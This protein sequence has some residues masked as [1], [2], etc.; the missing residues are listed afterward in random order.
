M[1]LEALWEAIFSENPSRIRAAWQQLSLEERSAVQTLLV[2]IVRDVQRIEEQRQA[3]RV[4]LHALGYDVP[5]SELSEM[6]MFAR[7]VAEDVGL[8]LEEGFGQLDSSLKADGSLVTRW[9]LIADQRIRSAIAARYPS[10]AI[11]SEEHSHQWHGEE[12]CWVIDPIDGTTN[13]ACGVPIWG[14]S[15]GLLRQG[16]PVLGV[17]EFPMFQE[18]Y[19]A[20]R[21][22]G[23]W[24]NGKRVQAQPR[25][26]P[27]IQPNDLFACCTRTLQAGPVR[28]PA[29]L[30]VPGTTAYNL[31]LV[32]RGACIGSFDL[33]VH[34]WDVAALWVV[35]AEAGVLA[36]TNLPSGLFP[37]RP[38][39]DYGQVTFS[40]L[41]AATEA[42]GALF[43]DFLSDRFTP[44]W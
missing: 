33:V 13:F 3:A 14:I 27:G 38:E 28:I 16:V 15:I 39:L 40:V 11:L 25:P 31:A 21:G 9:D 42:L 36:Y 26:A 32:A 20:V 35:L 29:K 41:T 34:L 44:S 22:G 43:A 8:E 2:N 6:L 17:A 10:H 30:R 23:A 5:N 37:L 4:A 1:D 12:W 24:L 7:T 18:Q 19:Y